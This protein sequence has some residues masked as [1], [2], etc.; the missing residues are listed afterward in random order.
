MSGPLLLP[1]WDQ[2]AAKIPGVTILKAWYNADITLEEFG[3]DI[4][5]QGHS[6][7][8]A[9]EEKDP[10]RKLSRGDLERALLEMIRKESSNQS[11]QPTGASR[12]SQSKFVGFWRLAPAADAGC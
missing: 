10:V 6:V 8:L 7:K 3:F 1:A 4:L 5:V 12:L 9:F 2:L 11:M